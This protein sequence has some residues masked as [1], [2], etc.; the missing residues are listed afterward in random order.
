MTQT[1]TSHLD[2]RGRRPD[3]PPVALVQSPRTIPAGW[4]LLAATTLAAL[5]ALAL[6]RL[7][8]A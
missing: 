2:M 7:A 6:T 5:T 8:A 1:K 3:A 4:F